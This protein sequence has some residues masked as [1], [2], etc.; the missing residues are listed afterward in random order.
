[1]L[2]RLQVVAQLFDLLMTREPGSRHVAQAQLLRHEIRP[3][4][5]LLLDQ[6]DR[7][8]CRAPRQGRLLLLHLRPL[9][10]LLLKLE[11]TL[12]GK[13]ERTHATTLPRSPPLP[14]LSPQE[15]GKRGE[16]EQLNVSRAMPPRSVPSAGAFR[17]RAYA[18]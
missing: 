11:D 9:L 16:G 17:R 7:L 8:L 1:M 10:P 5:H 15:R 12:Q 13:V 6:G 2:G 14:S 3:H 18:R 4:L